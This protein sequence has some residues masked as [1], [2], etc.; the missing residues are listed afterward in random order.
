MRGVLK[1]ICFL[2]YT[3]VRILYS[4][5]TPQKNSILPAY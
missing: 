3:H 4:Y 5:K 1:V 2:D